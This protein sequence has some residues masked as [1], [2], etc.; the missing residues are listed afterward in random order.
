MKNSWY[1]IHQFLSLL[2][3]VTTVYASCC[4]TLLFFDL[5]RSSLFW[6]PFMEGLYWVFSPSPPNICQPLTLL[7]R[8]RFSLSRSHLIWAHF[9]TIAS[10]LLNEGRPSLLTRVA[11]WVILKIWSLQLLAQGQSRGNVISS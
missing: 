9:S 10:E 2:W 6:T 3:S 4:S 1:L 7:V 8:Y 11:A 5:F